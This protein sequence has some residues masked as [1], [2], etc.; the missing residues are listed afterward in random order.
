MTTE[1][2]MPCS[3]PRIVR[4]VPITS[5]NDEMT[6]IRSVDVWVCL[7]ADQQQHVFQIMVLMC[8]QISLL[9]QSNEEGRDDCR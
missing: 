3:N 5:G 7:S 4:I 2:S 6:V 1:D 8:R 9:A